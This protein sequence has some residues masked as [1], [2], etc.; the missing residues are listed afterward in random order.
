MQR[1]NRKK[2]IALILPTKPRDGGQHQY[3]LVVVQCLIEKMGPEYEIE[4]LS[5]NSF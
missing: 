4:A 1:K 2:K 5:G 3:A